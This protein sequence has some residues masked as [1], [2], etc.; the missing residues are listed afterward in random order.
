MTF[1]TGW[2]PFTCAGI[3]RF[4]VLTIKCIFTFS[5]RTLSILQTTHHVD[6]GIQ[7]HSGG[8]YFEIGLQMLSY[9]H[10][11][12]IQLP[13]YLTNYVIVCFL[14]LVYI[15]Q[16]ENWDQH[17]PEAAELPS[18]KVEAQIGTL[19][20]NENPIFHQRRISF[21]NLRNTNP[22]DFDIV[23]SRLLLTLDFFAKDLNVWSKQGMLSTFVLRSKTSIAKAI[24]NKLCTVSRS[25]YTK[26]FAIC[27]PELWIPQ[28]K[29]FAS[30]TLALLFQALPLNFSNLR[31]AY[32]FA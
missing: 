3:R 21:L 8:L 18:F 31:P 17:S 19:S 2:W 11:V 28:T 12:L 23:L 10:Q 9:S 16:N 1:D 6:D 20:L 14:P 24:S 22:H 32:Q 5:N 4:S 26:S 27:L 7:S 30:E 29:P 15:F 13:L 25:V